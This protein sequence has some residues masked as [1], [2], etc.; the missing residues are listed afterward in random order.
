MPPPVMPAQVRQGGRRT[1]RAFDV[2]VCSVSSTVVSSFPGC[3]KSSLT[4]VPA[5][6]APPPPPLP[7]PLPP[8]PPPP[9]PPPRPR[10]LA[11]GDAGGGPAGGFASAQHNRTEDSAPQQCLMIAKTA[12]FSDKVK[13]LGADYRAKASMMRLEK[14]S[15]LRHADSSESHFEAECRPYI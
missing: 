10:C 8:P 9:P 1:T 5:A 2:M 7:P 15:S 11:D 12:D 13:Q 3:R 6:A 14:P 4:G